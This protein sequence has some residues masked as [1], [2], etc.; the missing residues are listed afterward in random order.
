RYGRAAGS[1]QLLAVSKTRTAEEIREAIAAGQR[2][3]GENYVQEALD[4]INA[5]NDED[6]EWHFIGRIQSN[7]T[8]QIAEH[9]DWVHSVASIKHARRLDEQ[10]PGHLPPLKVCLQVNVSGETSKSGF[11][12]DELEEAV[13]ACC[14]MPRL[15]L[16]GLM[17]L[18]APVDTEEAQRRPFRMLREMRDKVATGQCPL[19]TLSMGMSGDM[20]GAVAEGSTVVR[21]GTA[22]FGART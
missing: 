6:V 8:R 4:K 1:V 18:P 14:A 5:L 21:I 2:A 10:R 19:P 7:K 22:I 9:F 15:E 16:M 3:F 20:E 17:A 11:A 12:P 13:A